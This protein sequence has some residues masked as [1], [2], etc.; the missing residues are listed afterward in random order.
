MVSSS[1]EETLLLTSV[2]PVVRIKWNSSHGVTV[3]TC[4]SLSQAGFSR[5]TEPGGI[6][7][8]TIYHRLYFKELAHVTVG[9]VGQASGLEAR[10][11]VSPTVLRQK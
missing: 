4:W 10:A 3:C 7:R 11:G 1:V 9:T 5:G 2:T 6:D 8:W